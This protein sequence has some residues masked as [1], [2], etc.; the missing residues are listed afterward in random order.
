MVGID[1]MK[2][3]RLPPKCMC[4]YGGQ[5]PQLSKYPDDGIYISISRYLPDK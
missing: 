4:M 3:R 1:L 5:A 2:R